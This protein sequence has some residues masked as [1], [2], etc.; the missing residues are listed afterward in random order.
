MLK[1][2]QQILHKNIQGPGHRHFQYST[3]KKKSI[4][5]ATFQETR[6]ANK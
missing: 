3:C 4:T 2:N 1:G 5:L 6:V